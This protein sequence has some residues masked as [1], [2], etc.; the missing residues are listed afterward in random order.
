MSPNADR[1][2]V[3]SAVGGA[4]VTVSLFLAILIALP[5]QFFN[6]MPPGIVSIRSLDERFL[7]TS[8]SMLVMALTAVAQWDALVARCAR[9]R[10]PRLLPIPRAVIV[11]AK[12]VAMAL[13]ASA[14]SWRVESVADAVARGGD[15]SQAA[16]R[17]RRRAQADAGARRGDDRGGHLRLSRGARPARSRLR[18]ARADAVSKRISAALQASLVA[19]LM[20]A[21]LLLP[22]ASQSVAREWLARGGLDR[23][24][25]SVLVVRRTARNARRFG[26]RRSAAHAA[27]ALSRRP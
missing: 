2:V 25:T 15:A 1:H 22:S 27:R 7:F 11:R 4:L 16:D 17:L 14:W 26:H 6:L 21:L 20:T 13:F 10:R 5:Y 3:L 9:H 18:A 8:A 23:E 19:V 24:V 12:F